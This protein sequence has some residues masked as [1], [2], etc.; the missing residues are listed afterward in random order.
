MKRAA[1]AIVPEG[2]GKLAP[3]MT[4]GEWDQVMA[5][6]RYAGED[7]LADKLEAE[8]ELLGMPAIEERA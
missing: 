8:L 4:T 1:K 6:L 3:P 2:F 7:H 5:A